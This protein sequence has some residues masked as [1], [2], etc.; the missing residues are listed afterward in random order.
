MFL[1]KSYSNKDKN[2]ILNALNAK[3]KHVI[4]FSKNSFIVLTKTGKILKLIN[5]IKNQ[6]IK[7]YEIIKYWNRILLTYLVKDKSNLSF[8]H[9]IN[10]PKASY[11]VLDQYYEF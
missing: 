8:W 6:K 5:T 1:I 11:K 7:N 3:A 4:V 10:K 9:D 2:L